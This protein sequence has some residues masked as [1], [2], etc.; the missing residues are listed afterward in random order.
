MKQQTRTVEL[1]QLFGI[2]DE[3]LSTTSKERVMSHTDYEVCQNNRNGCELW[4]IVYATHQVVNM[5]HTPSQQLEAANRNY[6]NLHQPASMSLETYFERFNENIKA[7]KEAKVTKPTDQDQAVRFLSG[8]NRLLFKELHHQL[9]NLPHFNL[10]YPQDLAT[11]YRLAVNYIPASHQAMAATERNIFA[12]STHQQKKPKQNQSHSLQNRPNS[13]PLSSPPS[14]VPT[15]SPSSSG[16]ANSTTSMF[17]RYCKKTNHT[18]EEC[19]KLKKNH[20]ESFQKLQNSKEV[21][22]AECPLEY[23]PS[24]FEYE[25]AL[26]ESDIINYD[27]ENLVLLDTC[28]QVSIFHN[29]NLLSNITPVTDSVSITGLSKNSTAITPVFKGTLR[30]FDGVTIYISKETKRNILCFSDIIRNFE[31]QIID[32]QF[33]VNSSVGPIIFLNTHNVV[34]QLFAPPVEICSTALWT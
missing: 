8:L 16:G 28:A 26:G 32:Q 34:A 4:R 9:N 3:L 14:T 11:A 15:P 1:G 6:Y 33:H 7:L 12:T 5:F 20:P 13:K 27:D 24:S 23:F 31:V 10:A 19:N 22:L 18:V 17:C 2:I 30:G 21:S 29:E 25:I